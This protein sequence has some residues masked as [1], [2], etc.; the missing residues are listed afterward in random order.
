MPKKKKYWK[1]GVTLIRHNV[2]KLKN[3]GY[4]IGFYSCSEGNYQQEWET[5][6]NAM[7]INR[8]SSKVFFVTV[9]KAGQEV[10][11]LSGCRTGETSC[12][13]VGTS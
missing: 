4:V 5:E 3:A 6:Y 2:Q 9:T 11:L 1:H 10:D 7:I 8:I 12:I 13:L